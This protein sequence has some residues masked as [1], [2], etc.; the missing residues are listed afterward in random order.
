MDFNELKEKRRKELD[1]AIKEK[2]ELISLLE[3]K[4]DDLDKFKV[5]SVI[6]TDKGA[7]Y[8]IVDEP[9]LCSDCLRVPIRH[10]VYA[11]CKFN[12]TIGLNMSGVIDCVDIYLDKIPEV[13]VISVKEVFER[14]RDKVISSFK[15]KGEYYDRE[16]ERITDDIEKLKLRYEKVALDKRV[17]NSIDI[18]SKFD[19]MVDEYLDGDFK[20]AAFPKYKRDYRDY[21]GLIDIWEI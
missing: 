20:E 21:K 17:Y 8:L 4:F 13:K 3:R 16:L 2:E 15:E 5:G 7:Y 14:D 9:V 18:E 6:V 1:K 12:N 11:E 19:R 10:H